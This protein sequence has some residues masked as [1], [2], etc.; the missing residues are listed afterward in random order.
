LLDF[1]DIVIDEVF[2]PARSLKS[3]VAVWPQ[4]RQRLMAHGVRIP[5]EVPDEPWS[6]Q[7]GFLKTRFL[8]ATGTAG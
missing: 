2:V 6:E 1:R 8:G 5:R 7:S 4:L 3:R